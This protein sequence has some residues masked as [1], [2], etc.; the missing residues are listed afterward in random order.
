M[1]MMITILPNDNI[2]VNNN[3]KNIRNDQSNDRFSF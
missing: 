2:D 1:T 3:D